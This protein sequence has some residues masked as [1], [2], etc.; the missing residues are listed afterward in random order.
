MIEVKHIYIKD[1]S[2]E[3]PHTPKILELQWN[4]NVDINLHSIHA[5]IEDEDNLY[6][7]ILQ[8]TVTAKHEETTI[9]M[10]E[11]EQAGVF[12]ISEISGE[13]LNKALQVEC[14]NILFPYVREAISSMVT[15]GGFPQLLLA[16]INFE[17]IYIQKHYAKKEQMTGKPH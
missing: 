13:E 7:S 6:E 2:F 8:I 14:P 1:A 3:S 15:K 12:Q 5:K 16:P 9:F 17:S 10:A 11:V 4:P